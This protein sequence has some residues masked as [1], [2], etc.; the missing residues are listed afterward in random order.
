MQAIRPFI[1][2]VRPKHWLKNGLLF[3]PILYARNLFEVDLFLGVV[4]AFIAF[5]LLSSAIYVVNDLVDV[6]RDRRHPIKCG[7]P[8]ASGQVGRR[9]A[10]CLTILLFLGGFSLAILGSDTI[11]VFLFALCY[12]LLNLAYSFRLKHYAIIDCFCIAA[13]FILR[14]YAG[15]AASHDGITEWLFLT[16]TAVSLFLAFGKRR[17]EMLCVSDA[18]TTRQVLTRYNLQF[19][20]GII[21]VTA[22][23]AVIFYALWAMA[24]AAAMV[25]TVPL[26]IFI[27]CRYLLMIHE[28]NAQGD[29]TSVIL[30]DSVLLTALGV[31]GLLSLAVLYL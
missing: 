24:N 27:V 18:G 3:V 30:G 14:I 10:V 5:C 23:L 19:L 20:N 1:V 2:L 13:G 4:W 25:Y 6:E 8:I 17:G 29:P 9:Q 31:F 16:M 22:G 28:A 12:V 15:G 21:F 7:R 11:F 26:V